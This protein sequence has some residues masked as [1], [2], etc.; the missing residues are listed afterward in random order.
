MHEM[1]GSVLCSQFSCPIAG[2]CSCPIAGQFSCPLAGQTADMLEPLK[3]ASP[4]R[5]A[6]FEWVKEIEIKTGILI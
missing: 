5:T 1:A 3:G 4:L 2:Q 6:V